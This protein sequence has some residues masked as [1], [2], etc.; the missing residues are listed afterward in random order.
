MFGT[1][2]HTTVTHGVL[3]KTPRW[4]KEADHPPLS[5]HQTIVQA[6]VVKDRIAEHFRDVRWFLDSAAIVRLDEEQC[7]WRVQYKGV[8]TGGVMLTPLRLSIV[9][10]MDGTPVDPEVGKEPIPE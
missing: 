3:S 9:V 2:L 10:L 7:Y 5:P 8:S 1:H 4:K 6:N